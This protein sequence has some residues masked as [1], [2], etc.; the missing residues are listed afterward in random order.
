[1]KQ[2]SVELELRKGRYYFCKNSSDEIINVFS[3]AQSKGLLTTNQYKVLTSCH[4][5]Q[6][7]YETILPHPIDGDPFAW[8]DA[9]LCEGCGYNA[10][11]HPYFADNDAN[12]QVSLSESYSYINSA[13]ETLGQDVQ[14]YPVDS[15]F[16]IVEY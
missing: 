13:L 4:S 2:N 3:Q 10:Y 15:D 6:S 11:S 7:S 5:S 16:T 8:F 1:L 12:N 14:I 9:V